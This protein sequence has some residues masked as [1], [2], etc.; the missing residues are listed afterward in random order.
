VILH[1]AP[2]LM[3]HGMGA[4][5][6]GDVDSRERRY[7]LSPESFARQLEQIR[8]AGQR[9]R[10]LHDVWARPDHQPRLS[11]VVLTFDDGR[12]SD[13]AVAFPLLLAARAVAEFFV[14]TA[15]IGRPGYL[16]WGQAAEMR[17]AGMSFQSH[18][19][20]HVVLP[21]LPRHLL[22]NQLR[23]SKQLLEDR[24]GGRV[25]FLAA[26]YGLFDRSVVA[27]ARE[28]GYRAVCTSLAWPARPLAPT[29]NRV[30]VFRDTTEQRLAAILRRQASGYVPAAARAALLYLP[31]RVLLRLDPRRL[32]AQAPA[33][34]A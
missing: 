17:R 15:T 16:T 21:G 14:N 28:V 19:H 22:A 6:P 23:T 25:D 8:A 29:I 12:V 10:T 24:L 18:A 1:G 4:S 2:V 31:K 33:E 27:A 7:W 30:A 20:D 32:G 26:P 3:Y 5:I 13:Y 9:I 11:P 34:I